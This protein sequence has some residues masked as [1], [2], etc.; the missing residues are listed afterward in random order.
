MCKSPV[1]S[2]RQNYSFS[3]DNQR[4]EVSTPTAMRIPILIS[5]LGLALVTDGLAAGIPRRTPSKSQLDARNVYI[6]KRW[7]TRCGKKT[8]GNISGNKPELKPKPK[9]K[10]ESSP[11]SITG[12]APAPIIP[13]QEQG[14]EESCPDIHIFGARETT[15]PPGFGTASV[16][17]DLVLNAKFPGAGSRTVTAE[18]IEYPAAGGTAYSA[19]VGEGIKAVVNQT[20]LFAARCPRSVIIMHGYSQVCIWF[21]FLF[22]GGGSVFG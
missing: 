7:K 22:W 18:A 14:Q 4:C 1:L 3:V 16:L 11:P 19:S 2:S 8:P 21:F 12:P 6:K 5:I 20:N 13:G 17:I 15:A 9:P 10:L